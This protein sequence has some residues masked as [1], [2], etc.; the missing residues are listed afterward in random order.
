MESHQISSDISVPKVL[1]ELV[2]YFFHNEDILK[3]EGIFRKCG[4]EAI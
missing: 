3:L 1:F 2:K 4:S